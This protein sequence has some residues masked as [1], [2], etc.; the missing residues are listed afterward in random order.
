MGSKHVLV[1]AEEAQAAV[2]QPHRRVA[3]AEPAVGGEGGRGL[4]GL[5]VVL[6]H[7]RAAA[8]LQFAGDARPQNRAAAVIDD[9]QLEARPRPARRLA[10]MRLVVIERGQRHTQP[11]LGHAITGEVLDRRQRP[12]AAAHHGRGAQH[13]GGE[14]ARAQA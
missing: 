13:A 12:H 1:A 3:G 6:R 9:A 7:H 11:D 5:A 10:A 8:H 2:G 14:D 4:G